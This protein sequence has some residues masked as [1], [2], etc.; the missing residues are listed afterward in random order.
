MFP[1]TL[2]DLELLGLREKGRGA[3]A[4]GS[5]FPRDV[6]AV[7]RRGVWDGQ[8]NIGERI[9]SEWRGFQGYDVFDVGRCGAS[10]TR[11][12]AHNV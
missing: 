11:V 3:I 6:G 1:L 5:S 8:R 2:S 7:L 9:R 12:C 4:S 10:Y